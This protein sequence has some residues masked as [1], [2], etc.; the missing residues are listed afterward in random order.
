MQKEKLERLKKIEEFK[1]QPFEEPVFY[2]YKPTN[3]EKS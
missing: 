3:K 2:I 1:N